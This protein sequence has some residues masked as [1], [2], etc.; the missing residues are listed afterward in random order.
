MKIG[1]KVYF[2]FIPPDVL[3]KMTEGIWR[4]NCTRYSTVVEGSWVR[5]FLKLSKLSSKRHL[6]N[7]HSIPFTLTI[8]VLV[9]SF[10]YI[11][12]RSRII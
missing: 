12:L 5:P 1:S 4:I 7:H 8:V 6:S 11:F 10:R 9:F 3:E 2:Y